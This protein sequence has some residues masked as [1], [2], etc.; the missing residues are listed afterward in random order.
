MNPVLRVRPL[1]PPYCGDQG[2]W[3]P[4][5]SHQNQPAIEEPDVLTLAIIDGMGHGA[6]AE[7]SA[8]IAK[9]YIAQHCHE[10]DLTQIITGCDTVLRRTRGATMVI[11]RVDYQQHLFSFAGI[12]NCSA[13]IYRSDHSSVRL[14]SDIGIVGVGF[15]RLLVESM[16]IQSG[17]LIVLHTD[18]IRSR[19]HFNNYGSAILGDSSR[20]ADTIMADWGKQIDD[21]A[22]LVVQI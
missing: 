20:L 8:L 16:P 4:D 19:M 15:S 13:L 9:S 3:W 1:D 17:D 6:D 5:V 21:A 11:G 14:V 2:G 18:G 12:G 7:Q 10:L 22:V